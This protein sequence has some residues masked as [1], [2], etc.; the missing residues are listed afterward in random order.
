MKQY[1]KFI[2]LCNSCVFFRSTNRPGV[3]GGLGGFGG[4][5]RVN[6]A[7]YVKNNV[8]T[9][10]KDPILVMGTDGVGTKLKVYINL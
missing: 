10:Y 9:R 6:D 4:L 5:F 1:L 2:N 7:S 8:A 3:I